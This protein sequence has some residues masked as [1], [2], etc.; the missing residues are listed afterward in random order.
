MPKDSKSP[1]KKVKKGKSDARETKTG[2]QEN[3]CFVICP[4]GGWN[5]RYYLDVYKPAVESAGLEPKRADDLYR[6]SAI[7]ND[8]WEFVRNSRVLLADLTGK[9]PNVFYELG[10][11]HAI[12]KPVVMVT[13]SIND[14]PFDLRA[15]RVI[16]FEIEDPQWSELLKE[17]I[18]K[19]LREVLGAP[20]QA[21][22]PTFLRERPTDRKPTV[23]PVERR[24]LELQQQMELLRAET[25]SRADRFTGRMIGAT[26][27]EDLIRRW[28][29][30][31][32][33][34]GIILDR[35][36]ERGVPLGWAEER[37]RELALLSQQ[38]PLKQTEGEQ[39]GGQ[40]PPPPSSKTK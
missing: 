35:L 21:V 34:P 12:G 28:L 11:A 40:T 2:R 23:T 19:S 20:E 31:G 26:E 3:S 5:D 13:R 18:V 4:F 10:L 17:K 37:I 25:R 1:K 15:L 29:E 7:V 22:L 38:L 16:E 6:P 14:V 36:R 39:Q 27:A 33:P 9:N 8:I 30:R 24:I 32:M